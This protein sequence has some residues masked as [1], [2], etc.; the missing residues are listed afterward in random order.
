LSQIADFADEDTR[1][2]L[3]ALSADVQASLALN[4]AVLQTLAAL[5]PALNAAAEQ[6][7]EAELDQ[8]HRQA[9]PQRTVQAIEEVRDLIQDAPQEIEKMSALERALIAAAERLPDLP[10][11]EAADTASMARG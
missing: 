2:A 1:R 5:S 3:K 11:L 9:A 4:R 8:A 7:L 10:D 6:A